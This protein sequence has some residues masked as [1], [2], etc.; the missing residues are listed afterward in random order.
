MIR[1]VT[2]AFSLP[3]GAVSRRELCFDQAAVFIEDALQVGGTC[4]QWLGLGSSPGFV[5]TG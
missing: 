2:D 4:S 5:G 3:A 1:L